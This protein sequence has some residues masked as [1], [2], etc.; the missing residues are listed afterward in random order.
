[1]P[2]LQLD[3]PTTLPVAT[4][5]Q[6]ARRLGDLYA[7]AMET[8]ASMVNVGFRELGEGNLYRCGPGEPEP[9]AVIHC[10]IRRGR[11][12]EQRLAFARQLVEACVE[13]LG[14]PSN[15]VA[16]EFTQ[17]TADEMYRDGSWGREWSAS[18]RAETEGAQTALPTT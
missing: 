14:L 1:M 3:L 16:V 5:R 15:R 7:A 17:H 12:P 11:P 18:E 4:K 8:T 13:H 10:D 6:L 2:Y 9:A